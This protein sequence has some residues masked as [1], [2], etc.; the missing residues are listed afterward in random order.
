[1]EDFIALAQVESDA[2]RYPTV[3]EPGD[4]AKARATPDPSTTRGLQSALAALRF[5]IGVD[6]QIREGTEGVLQSFQIIA[7]LPPTKVADDATKAAL[8][9]ALSGSCTPTD[10]AAV[11]SAREKEDRPRESSR[12]DPTPRLAL[13][14]ANAELR[15]TIDYI[16]MLEEQVAALAHVKPVSRTDTVIGAALKPV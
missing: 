9:K 8:L 12:L 10:F 15:V 4:P 13:A 6:G 11:H 3:W 5:K 2:G 1:M 14:D 16:A 7:G